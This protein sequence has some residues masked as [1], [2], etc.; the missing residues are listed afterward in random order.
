[1]G[2]V[3]SLEE[4]GGEADRGDGQDGKRKAEEPKATAVHDR[5]ALIPRNFVGIDARA[6]HGFSST[7]PGGSR[8]APSKLPGESYAVGLELCSGR[9]GRSIVA[10]ARKGASQGRFRSP[11]ALPLRRTA[12]SPIEG[13][14]IG[15][16]L[17]DGCIGGSMTAPS[18]AARVGLTI[19][20]SLALMVL[21]APRGVAATPSSWNPE[22][23]T[24]R[25]V[26]QSD[27]NTAGI[28]RVTGVSQPHP[29]SESQAQ[30]VSDAQVFAEEHPDRRPHRFGAVR[31][32][33]RAIPPFPVAWPGI[34][35]LT[36]TSSLAGRPRAKPA[37]ITS[38]SSTRSG[39]TPT[40]VRVSSS[41]TS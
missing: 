15:V 31:L 30:A 40:M 10:E 13:C 7:A 6:A 18:R 29:K 33:P 28:P 34:A 41:R 35:G 12:E 39:G 11:N 32:H 4:G 5:A 19:A 9:Y 38:T 3:F 17:A 20:L 36:K 26:I 37:R 23:R 25:H 1:M 8:W 22:I 2:S 27:L 21:M 24:P 16:D 14:D